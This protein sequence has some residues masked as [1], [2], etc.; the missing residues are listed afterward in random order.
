MAK[1]ILIISILLTLTA[2]HP[3]V[4]V[5]QWEISK[6]AD[7]VLTFHPEYI[8]SCNYCYPFAAVGRPD[9]IFVSTL[10]AKTLSRIR[11]DQEL[12]KNFSVKVNVLNLKSETVSQIELDRF[13]QV[14]IITEDFPV[15]RFSDYPDLN[16]GGEPDEHVYV[17]PIC[18][19]GKEFVATL[20]SEHKTSDRTTFG[21]PGILPFMGRQSWFQKE[22]YY[23][24]IFFLEVFDKEKPLE[25]IVQ[26][27]KRFRNLENLPDINEMAKWTQGTEQ[28][29]LMAV[30]EGDP[31]SG[32]KGKI[33]LI[34]PLE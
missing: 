25:P 29:F 27:Q 33:F 32:I 20:S 14:E 4:D 22:T 31:R 6:G 21:I 8:S 1:T 11:Q 24:G 23:S 12:R 10:K 2:C 3:W 15:N 7:C 28:P 26:L 16:H 30:N 19:K 34:R 13:L 17:A 9:E 5:G 18:K